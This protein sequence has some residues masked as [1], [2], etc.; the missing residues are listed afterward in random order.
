MTQ[1]IGVLIYSSIGVGFLHALLGPDHYL[2]FIALA[3][4]RRLSWQRSLWITFL[5]GLGH[6]LSSIFLAGGLL[7]LGVSLKKIGVIDSCRAE[8]TSWLFMT[9]GLVYMVWALKALFA[10]KRSEI[11][12]SHNQ[13]PWILFILFVLGPCEPLLAFLTHPMLA[14]QPGILLSITGLFGLTTLATMLAC[15]A[16]GFLLT[17][18]FR[19]PVLEKYRHVFASTIFFFCGFGMRFLGW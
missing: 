14:G 3:K 12:N 13:T 16:S 11:L 4:A 5:C 17:K 9:C 8:I 6:L 10:D 7:L 19:L 2:P 1:E 15:V 18:D